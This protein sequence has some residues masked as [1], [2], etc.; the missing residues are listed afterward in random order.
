[1]QRVSR[2]LAMLA[3]A[4]ATALTLSACQ[5]DA[6]QAVSMGSYTLSEQDV[7]KMAENVEPTLKKL[8]DAATAQDQPIQFASPLGDA[9]GLVVS[10]S[11]FNEVARRYTQE[12]RISVPAPDYAATA[13]Q[14]GFPESDPLL[15]LLAQAN[16]YQQALGGAITPVKPTDADI[17]EIY[18]PYVERVRAAGQEP[19]ATFEDAREGL[20]NDPS[21][22]ANL[23]IRNELV[24]AM[25]RYGLVVN[26]RYAPLTFSLQGDQV[27]VAVPLGDQGT[28]A[29]RDV[30]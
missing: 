19:T 16:S 14:F 25:Q 22:G 15:R 30:G 11:A 28:G 17:H 3:L 24:A 21:F 5:N 1:M 26:P 6:T 7:E 13:K 23:A 8:N 9:R 18:D 4:A 20:S 12:K 10:F 2:R 27:G 29:V